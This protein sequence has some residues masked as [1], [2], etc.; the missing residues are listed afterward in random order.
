MQLRDKLATHTWTKCWFYVTSIPKCNCCIEI[1]VQSLSYMWNL[2]KA[3]LIT[4]L[5]PTD[6]RL[7]VRCTWNLY[8]TH[9]KKGSI[10]VLCESLTHFFTLTYRLQWSWNLYHT[11][12]KKG[13]ILVLCESLTHFF[14]LTY[15]LQ[16]SWNPY[17]THRNKGSILVLYKCESMTQFFTLTYRFQVRVVE[18]LSHS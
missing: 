18:S 3:W 8:H 13:S 14:T 9:R 6:F 7:G 5:W 4:I 12:R 1:S 2:V 15:R 10:L 17:H 16:G 11:H